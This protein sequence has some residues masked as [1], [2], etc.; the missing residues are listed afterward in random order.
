MEGYLW[1]QER[2]LRLQLNHKSLLAIERAGET[3][4]PKKE[5]GGICWPWLLVV[6]WIKINIMT[7]LSVWDA[8][9]FFF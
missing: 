8:C 5:R 4:V 1:L 9:F 6:S 7:Y 2:F 3:T